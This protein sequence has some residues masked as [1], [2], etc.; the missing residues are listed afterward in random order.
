MKGCESIAVHAQTYYPTCSSQKICV[1][2]L[3]LGRSLDISVP[4][5]SSSVVCLKQITHGHHPEPGHLVYLKLIGNLSKAVHAQTYQEPTITV[6]SL[7]RFSH[8]HH[9]CMVNNL[10]LVTCPRRSRTDRTT[11]LHRSFGHNDVNKVPHTRLSLRN[12]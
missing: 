8:R 7:K 3:S 5:R 1:H 2:Y 6:G 4:L 11:N 9:L 12:T 10:K